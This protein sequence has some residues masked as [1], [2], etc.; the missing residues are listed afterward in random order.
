MAGA[1]TVLI[2]TGVLQYSA[3][4][5]VPEL[6]VGYKSKLPSGLTVKTS[7]TSEAIVPYL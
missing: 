5:T 7:G 4:T 1:I 6:G 2:T 3:E